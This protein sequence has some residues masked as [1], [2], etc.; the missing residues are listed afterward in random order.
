MTMSQRVGSYREPTRCD[1]AAGTWVACRR[2]GS[3]VILR[4]LY[5]DSWSA[6]SEFNRNSSGSPTAQARAAQGNAGGLAY[7][8]LPSTAAIRGRREGRGSLRAV[9]VESDSAHPRRAPARRPILLGGS[10]AVP[11]PR[12][13]PQVRLR[14]RLARLQPR[15][16][17][18]SQGEA[19]EHLRVATGGYPPPSPP[20]RGTRAFQSHA[21]RPTN[22]SSG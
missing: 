20:L 14:A 9:L 15:D 3:I 1:L 21:P 17:R 12:Q 18:G 10:T 11:P 19:R 4:T 8:S 6:P 5:R 22:V 7:S 13:P 2:A 16:L